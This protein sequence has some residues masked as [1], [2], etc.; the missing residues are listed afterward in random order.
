MFA[1]DAIVG[2]VQAYHPS[3]VVRPW[4]L[5]DTSYVKEST[6]THPCAY[7]IG[8]GF[9]CQD[10]SVVG[11][12]RRLLRTAKAPVLVDGGA[13]RL[14]P[15]RKIRD[16]CER[17]FNDGFPTIITPHGGEAAAM[18]AVFGLETDD[19]E[20]LA[21]ELSQAY[22]AITVLKGP[23]TYISDGDDVYCMDEGTPALAKAGTGDVLAGILGALLAQG[24]GPIE[25]CVLG[26]TLHAH[27]GALA[28]RDLSEISVCAED[29]IAYLPKAILQMKA[30]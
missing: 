20:R 5:W 24:L 7:V 17:R 2:Q 23:D 12:T 22:G 14:M 15:A 19:P 8:C 29:V 6:A 10:P 9:N 3:L 30:Q 27:A 16:L 13:L 4:S 1:E 21:V 28:A 18:A 26:T 11:I 25:A